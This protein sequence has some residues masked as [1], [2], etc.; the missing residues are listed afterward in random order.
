MHNLEIRSPSL[1]NP[2]RSGK[3]PSRKS[4]FPTLRS[5]SFSSA[6]PST[7]TPGNMAEVSDIKLFGKW[8]YDD[9]DVSDHPLLA[10]FPAARET[11]KL[12]RVKR[13]SRIP[14]ASGTPRLTT[15]PRRLS[16]DQRHLSRGS[17]LIELRASPTAPLRPRVVVAGTHG[18]SGGTRGTRTATAMVFCRAASARVQDGSARRARRRSPRRRV[19]RRRHARRLRPRARSGSRERLRPVRRARRRRTRA[20]FLGF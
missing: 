10:P 13:R 8:S 20:D 3:V 17:Y 6:F 4:L 15:I 2:N 14:R 7:A 1:A 16:A 9:V 11:G 12:F 5:P 18:P 19:R